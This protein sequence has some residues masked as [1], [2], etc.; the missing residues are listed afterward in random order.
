MDSQTIIYLLS[1]G[2]INIQERTEMGIWPHSP[3]SFSDLALE[4]TNYLKNHQWFPEEW[5]ERNDGDIIV[6]AAVIERLSDNEFMFRSRQRNPKDITLIA[7]RTEKVFVSAEQ[8][9]D[10]Y[11]RTVL[12]LPGRLDKWTVVE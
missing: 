10:Y 1:G 7:S 4:L 11:L 5:V 3:L 6:D 2:H 12:G 9:A 8:A